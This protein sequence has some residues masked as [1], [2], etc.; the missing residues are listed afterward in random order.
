[1][2][3][4]EMGG[5]LLTIAKDV[6]VQVEFNPA[7]VR[8]YRLIGYENRVLAAE[9]FQDDEKDAG[10]LGAGHSVTALYEVVPVGA[11]TP[12]RGAGP[13]RYQET[14]PRAGTRETAELLTVALRY[15]QPD[16]QTS[17]LIERPVADRG[18]GLERTSDDFRFAAAVAEWGLLLRDSK[19]KGA[20]S[21]SDVL[22]LARGA[23]ADDPGGY[24]AEFVRLVEDSRRIAARERPGDGEEDVG[25]HG[26]H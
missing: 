8:A 13:L 26:G 21:W 18:A 20:S 15:K 23:L 9:D 7:R 24:R 25:G 10:E 11:P 17:R 22:G 3:V 12:V 4:R 19:F 5:T 2:L 1:M 6:K 16:G 14:R